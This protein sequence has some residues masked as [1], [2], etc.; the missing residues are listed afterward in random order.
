MIKETR[1]PAADPRTPG[2]RLVS[3][4]ALRGC[5]AVI[6]VLHHFVLA[7]LPRYIG[8]T[9]DVDTKRDLIGSPF[10]V[11]LNGTGMVVVF[12][13][14]SGYVLAQK[15]LRDN[16]P[17]LLLDAAIKRWFRLTPLILAAALLSYGLFRCGCYR[18]EDAAALS[19]SDWLRHFSY[20]MHSQHDHPALLL[21]LRQGLWGT[22]LRGDASLDSSLWTMNIEFV[23]S[24]VVFG[25]ALLLRPPCRRVLP[26]VLLGL[27]PLLIV[28]WPWMFPF[29]L[30]V[31][32]CLLPLRGRRLP[33]WVAIPLTVGGLYLA[34]C[35]VEYGAPGPGGA[36]AWVRRITPSGLINPAVSQIVVVCAAGALLLMIVFATENAVS[37]WFSGRVARALGAASFPLYVVHV[38]IINSFSARAYAAAGG[39]WRGLLAAALTLIAIV[40][41]MVWVLSV[42]DK[43]W[44]RLLRR[45]PAAP[46]PVRAPGWRSAHRA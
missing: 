19:G 39:S 21:A 9:P 18:F 37:R 4:E 15:G 45:W 17:A 33:A 25:L 46:L 27:A 20:G 32:A 43:G 22:L 13:V 44:L 12:F 10:F 16:A 5:A 28:R 23:G 36:Y 35:A 2:G 8:L 42:F 11:F 6:V 14:L 24:F 26:F 29:V 38:L 1:A 41:P 30:G 31:G 34:G 40:A 3:L 7:F